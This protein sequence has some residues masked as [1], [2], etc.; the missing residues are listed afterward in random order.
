[1]EDGDDGK[2]REEKPKI[3]GKKVGK[4]AK[5]HVKGGG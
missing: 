1:V 4:K 2:K 5:G 3:L